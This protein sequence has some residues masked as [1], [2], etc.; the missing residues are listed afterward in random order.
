MSKRKSNDRKNLLRR[1]QAEFSRI[2]TLFDGKECRNP[3]CLCRKK[4]ATGQEPTFIERIITAH[5]IIFKSQGGA[6]TAEN[7]INLCNL[8]HEAVQ[9]GHGKGDD[10]LTGHQFMLKILDSLIDDPGYRWGDVHEQL[11][12][13]QGD[14]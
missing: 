4:R 11:K 13:R 5:H 2:V 9:S 1:L 6:Y 12:R 3:D 14:G 10:R 8:C 7:G